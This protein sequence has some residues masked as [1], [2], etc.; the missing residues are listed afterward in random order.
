MPKPQH[1]EVRPQIGGTS[2]AWLPELTG[3]TGQVPLAAA[4]HRDTC[5]VFKNSSQR[6]GPSC[7][8]T[9]LHDILVHCCAVE[10]GYC[11]KVII[12][13]GLNVIKLWTARHSSRNSI[14]KE[15]GKT[16]RRNRLHA[17]TEAYTAQTHVVV[18]FLGLV[19]L[20]WLLLVQGFVIGELI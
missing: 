16:G 3:I 15:A 9:H 1:E 10:L 17:A 7:L 12:V 4:S 14:S 2:A 19:L 5:K 18:A 6:T 11:T 8:H 13:E 20:V